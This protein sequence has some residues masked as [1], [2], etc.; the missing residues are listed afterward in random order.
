M[1]QHQ[2]LKRIGES[3]IAS[4]ICRVRNFRG[5]AAGA[6]DNRGVDGL[7]EKLQDYGAE[8]IWGDKK[9]LAWEGGI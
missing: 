9:T 1:H 8:E 5:R 4:A 7:G 2:A 3:L 6:M